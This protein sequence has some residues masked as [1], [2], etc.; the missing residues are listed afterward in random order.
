MRHGK[1]GK[2]LG[3]E[4]A[5][6]E[7]LMRGLAT[8]LIIYEKI[9]TTKAK[10]KALRPIVEKVITIGKKDTLHHRRQVA[11]FLYLPGSVSKL[12]DVL[13]PRFR[14]R[15][16]G[17]TR[18]IKLARRQGDAAEMAIIELVEKTGAGQIEAVK[19]DEARAVTEEKKEKKDK[20]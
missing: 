12:F 17:Y 8:D 13:G 16:G 1:K 11:G 2:I 7:A 14:E 20:Q 19:K 4:K 10:A 6:R 18:I 5:P 15:K 3:R 9:K